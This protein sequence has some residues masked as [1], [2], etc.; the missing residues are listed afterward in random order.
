MEMQNSMYR[1]SLQTRIS[2]VDLDLPETSLIKNIDLVINN[3]VGMQKILKEGQN[4]EKIIE[5]QH[6]DVF[7]QIKKY[8]QDYYKLNIK[9]RKL[10]EDIKFL[11]L[12]SEW[13]IAEKE[14][15]DEKFFVKESS[16]DYFGNAVVKIKNIMSII[17]ENYDY[18]P[19]IVSLIDENDSKQEIESLAEFF[20]INFIQIFSYLIQNKKNY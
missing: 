20:V 19:K 6:L 4:L 17:R 15:E 9:S 5:K 13:I 2:S 11:K 8:I 10:Y 16:G 12:G 1:E 18:I 3:W 14:G 7:D